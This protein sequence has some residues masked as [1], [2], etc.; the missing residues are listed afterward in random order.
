M[1]KPTRRIL[2]SNQIEKGAVMNRIAS[3]LGLLA[4]AG[5]M[6]LAGTAADARPRL[7]GEEQLAKL[8][9]GRVAG[10]PVNCI[11]L[12]NVQSSRV[13]DKTAIVYGSGSTIY[14]Q[15]PKS[16][17]SSLN[18]DDILVTQLTTS[19]LCNIDVVQLRDRNG[20]FWR[21]FVALDKFVPY[22]RPAKVALAD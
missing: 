5:A 18:S 16:G 19:Q 15:R 22:T 21:G 13:I 17:A 20:W 9:E 11:N 14:V 6:M 10:Q 8:L 3:K 12:P 2:V 1:V 7:T 4:A